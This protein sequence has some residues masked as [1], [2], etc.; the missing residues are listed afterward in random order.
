MGHNQAYRATKSNAECVNAGR[1]GMGCLALNELHPGCKWGECPFFKTHADQ[2]RQEAECFH[3][4]FRLGIKYKTR[5]EV[6]EEYYSDRTRKEKY[7]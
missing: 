6:I 1:L 2:A 5:A 3:R 4:C 7:R